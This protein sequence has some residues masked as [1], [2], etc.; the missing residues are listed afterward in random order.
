LQR[1]DGFGGEDEVAL[2]YQS[3]SAHNHPLAIYFTSS[4]Q[5]KFF[6]LGSME[7]SETI[8]LPMS[9]GEVVVADYYDGIF[10]GRD[11]TRATAH[12]LVFAWQGLTFGI[13]GS[14]VSGVSRD[15]LTRVANGLTL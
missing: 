5:E 15:E 10:S 3:L 11:W 2:W 8:R 1:D 14:R 4:P 9:N 13:R 7:R 12:S 6:G